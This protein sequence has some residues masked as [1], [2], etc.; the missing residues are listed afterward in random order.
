MKDIIKRLFTRENEFDVDFKG[1]TLKEMLSN[2]DSKY[3]VQS[4][5]MY[6]K[7]AFGENHAVLTS[8]TDA[9]FKLYHYFTYYPEENKLY[10]KSQYAKTVWLNLL[11][12][13]LFTVA[14]FFQEDWKSMFVA[15]FPFVG[16]FMLLLLL[17]LIVGLYSE[18]KDMEREVI[19]RINFKFRNFG[20]KQ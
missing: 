1:W 17:M 8:A 12:P 13:L 9:R 11:L 4:E 2:V 19:I 20:E 6:I 18:A 5:E 10:V 7:S 3:T 14:I 15:I 16:G